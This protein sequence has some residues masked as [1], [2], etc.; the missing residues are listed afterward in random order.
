MLACV[1]A[2]AQVY[3]RGFGRACLHICAWTCA[4]TLQRERLCARAIASV[5]V[6]VRAHT[7]ACSSFACVRASV[8]ALACLYAC[9]CV[10]I[11]DGVRTLACVLVLACVNAYMGSLPP[12]LTSVHAIYTLHKHRNAVAPQVNVL[13]LLVRR[14]ILGKVI[15]SW[16]G[17]TGVRLTSQPP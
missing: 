13:A 4:R 8:N 10:H 12:C 5:C 2:C 7:R 3:V 9:V 1:P 11:H 17:H 14:S 16:K 15:H 6:C